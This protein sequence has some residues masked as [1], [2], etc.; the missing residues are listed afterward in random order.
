MKI[1][2]TKLYDKRNLLSTLIFNSLGDSFKEIFNEK[3]G[4]FEKCGNIL[5]IKLTVNDLEIDVEKCMENWQKDIENRFDEYVKEN[6]KEQIDDNFYN[7][8]ELLNDLKDRISERITDCKY[9]WEK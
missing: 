1:E 6:L 7:A 5:D 4:F 3:P 9:D 8:I 2:V